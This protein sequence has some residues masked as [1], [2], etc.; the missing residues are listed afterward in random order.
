[1]VT[2]SLMALPEMTSL[3]FIPTNLVSRRG[4][5]NGLP[6]D[7]HGVARHEL[8]AAPGLD[9]PVDLHQ[10]A[11]QEVLRLA[12]VLDEVGELEQ[13]TEADRRVPD[14]DVALPGA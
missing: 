14:R 4:D 7:G 6:T 10:A 11:E 9:L 12:P 3:I 1:M 5:A 13:L 2:T 8:P